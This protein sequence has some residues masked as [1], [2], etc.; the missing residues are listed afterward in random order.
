MTDTNNRP[1]KSRIND[2]EAKRPQGD[3][4][5]YL[6]TVEWDE[7]DQIVERFYRDGEPIS[8]REYMRATGGKVDQITMDWGN[9][10]QD[11]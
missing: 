11:D 7:S 5:K 9:D 2:L 4:H 8:K 6:K 10:D 1:L 3:D